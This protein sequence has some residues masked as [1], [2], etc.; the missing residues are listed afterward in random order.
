MRHRRKRGRKLGRTQSHRKAMLR[1]MVT[2]FFE[3]EEIE[4]TDAKARELRSL[5][6]R[7]VTLGKRGANDLAARRQVAKIVRDRKVASK[8]FAEIGPRYADRPGGYTRILKVGKRLGDAASLSILQFVTE[9]LE[10]KERKPRQAEE[11]PEAARPAPEV[12]EAPVTEAPAEAAEA[13][14]ATAPS[15]N[16]AGS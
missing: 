15:T 8:L 16:E 5:A 2:S 14:T 13:A 7:L 10:F 11:A 1:N 6:E 9:P 3:H 4:T 12:R